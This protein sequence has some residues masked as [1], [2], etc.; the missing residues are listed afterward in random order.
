MQICN[1]YTKRESDTYTKKTLTVAKN[2][3]VVTFYQNHYVNVTLGTKTIR[4]KENKALASHTSFHFRGNH[5]ST[6]FG[7]WIINMLFKQA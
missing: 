3:T 1:I 5:T 2:A 6:K 7:N 4:Q